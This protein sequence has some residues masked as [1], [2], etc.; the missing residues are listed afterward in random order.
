MA[1]ASP[2]FSEVDADLRAMMWRTDK[3]GYA[4]RTI[5]KRP[6]PPISVFAHHDVCIRKYGRKPNHSIG[7]VSDHINRNRLDN[8]RENLRIVTRKENS[9]NSFHKHGCVTMRKD[10]RRWQVS[11]LG[12]YVGIRSTR[13]DAIELLNSVME[14]Q[15]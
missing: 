4:R 8:R 6:N 11:F 10:S 14:V 9:R 2:M 1:K 3:C 12:K 13:E 5:N 7:E 15:P